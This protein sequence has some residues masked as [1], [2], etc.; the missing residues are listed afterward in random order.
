MGNN[1]IEDILIGQNSK[2]EKKKGRGFLVFLILLLICAL[3]ALVGI[4]YNLINKKVSNKDQ[5]LTA[6]SKIDYKNI[7]N[8]DLLENLINRTL[9]NNSET[10]TEV[11]LPVELMVRDSTN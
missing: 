2:K 4:Y 7:R 5:F 3:V 6:A 1:G 8:V 10:E 9:K 11:M